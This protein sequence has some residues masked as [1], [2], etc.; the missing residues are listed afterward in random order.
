M[1]KRKTEEDYK[2]EESGKFLGLTK[3]NILVSL[4]I[5]I[6]IT[7]Y[8]CVFEIDVYSDIE[9]FN[10]VMYFIFSLVACC[11]GA[12]LFNDPGAIIGMFTGTGGSTFAPSVIC[13]I[14]HSIVSRSKK[15]KCECGGRYEP[16]D[17]WKWEEDEIKKTEETN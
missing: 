2:K 3:N 15:E 13:N 14:C 11:I 6:L 4:C 9:I 7:I 16:L 8:L 1:W 12:R 17:D 5:A 10:M